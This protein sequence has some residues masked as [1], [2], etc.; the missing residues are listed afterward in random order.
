MMWSDKRT[1]IR[2]SQRSA[3]NVPQRK[4]WK[5]DN[6]LL[7]QTR[8][9]IWGKVIK[10]QTDTQSGLGTV[11]KNQRWVPICPKAQTLNLWLNLSKLKNKTKNL[12]LK[13]T[14][15]YFSTKW[16]KRTS[17]IVLSLIHIW[18]CRRYSLCRSRWSPYH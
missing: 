9:K 1:R 17:N 12:W 5:P 13:A 11:G 3:T 16:A 7:F 15:E 14:V 18:R 2:N 10:F 4:I 8:Y 6:F